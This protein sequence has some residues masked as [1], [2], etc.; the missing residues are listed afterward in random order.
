MSGWP[1]PPDSPGPTGPGAEQSDARPADPGDG[2]PV[3]S[4][5]AQRMLPRPPSD[6]DGP[7]ITRNFLSSAGRSSVKPQTRRDR[8]LVGTLPGWEPLPPGEVVVS[9]PRTSP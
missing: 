9:K 6:N 3:V 4:R 5:R 2:A 7:V 8:K 1:T